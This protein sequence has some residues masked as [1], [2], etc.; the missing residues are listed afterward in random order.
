MSNL[1]LNSLINSKLN[2][3]NNEKKSII[4]LKGIP[5]EVVDPVNASSVDISSIITHKLEYFIEIND[6][7]KFLTYEEFLLMSDF[8]VSAYDQI[9]IY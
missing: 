2:D 8:I 9:Y 5:M 4:V 3:L 1:I 7:R 6:K